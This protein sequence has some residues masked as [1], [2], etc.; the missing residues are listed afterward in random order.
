MAVSDEILQQYE[1]T[2][3]IEC[4]VQL[5]DKY[6]L[7]EFLWER[8]KEESPLLPPLKDKK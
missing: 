6:D 3:G 7:G 8:A 1:M 4:H 5:A 2:I